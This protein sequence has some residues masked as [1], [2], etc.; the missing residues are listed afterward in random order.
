MTNLNTEESRKGAMACLDALRI[1]DR[2]AACDGSELTWDECWQNVD[3]SIKAAQ[4]TA[5]HHGDFISGFVATFAEYVHSSITAGQ[6]NL[7][8]F[9]P[10]ASMTDEEVKYKRDMAE[11]FAEDYENSKVEE[12]QHA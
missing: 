2:I 3:A 9:E 6:L 4:Y 8:K 7:Y 5:G 1:I 12:L 11:K 10:I